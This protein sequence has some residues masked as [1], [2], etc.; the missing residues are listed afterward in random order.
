MRISVPNPTEAGIIFW[1]LIPQSGVVLPP[2]KYFLEDDET[3][4][5]QDWLIKKAN[6]DCKKC[7]HVAS[8]FSSGNWISGN[9]MFSDFYKIFKK[10]WMPHNGVLRQKAGK[11]GFKS[12]APIFILMRCS[13]KAQKKF[14]TLKDGVFSKNKKHVL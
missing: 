12:I 13:L 1:V 8:Q 14:C 11:H 10:R 7:F 5:L 6:T 4:N 3:K 2:N 9:Q